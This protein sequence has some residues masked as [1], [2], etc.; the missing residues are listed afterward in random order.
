MQ[1]FP[2]GAAAVGGGKYRCE[3][4]EVFRERARACRCGDI[5]DNPAFGVLVRRNIAPR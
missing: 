1:A 3:G 2:S 5:R 4:A